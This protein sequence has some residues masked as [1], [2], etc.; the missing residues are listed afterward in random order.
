[1][2][3]YKLGEIRICNDGGRLTRPVLRVKNNKV[4][5]TPDIINQLSNNKLVWN[6]LLTSCRLDESVIEYIESG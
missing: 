1:M 6:D 3:D 2:F 5:I 4:I